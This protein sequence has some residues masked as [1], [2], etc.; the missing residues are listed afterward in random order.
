VCQYPHAIPAD[1]ASY[2]LTML[3]KHAR[4]AVQLAASAFIALHAGVDLGCPYAGFH[5][6][7][8]EQPSHKPTDPLKRTAPGNLRAYS[9]L[10][11]AISTLGRTSGHFVCDKS[12]LRSWKSA[13]FLPPG[14]SDLLPRIHSGISLLSPFLVQVSHLFPPD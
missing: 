13:R 10:H 1:I 3:G 4:P 11:S 12:W 6:F 9:H 8:P 7:S 2:L 14:V 5:R